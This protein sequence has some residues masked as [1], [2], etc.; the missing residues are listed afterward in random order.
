MHYQHRYHAGNFADVF[1]H[2][3]LVGLL[4]ALNRKESP[5]CYLETHAGTGLYDLTS[6]TADRTGEFRDG[7]E[8]LWGLKGASEP[9]TRY[10][11]G[12]RADNANGQLRN[13]PGSPRVAQSFMRE[14]DRLVL[15][16]KVPAM[17]DQLKLNLR[18]A[19]IH[20][21][22]GY[23]AISLL[24]PKEKRALILID[25][26]FE[27][28]DEFEACNEF[29]RA[30]LARFSQGI[31]AVW[32]PLKNAHVA[33]RFKRRAATLKRAVLTMEFDTGAKGEETRFASIARSGSERPRMDA[34]AGGS[35]DDAASAWMPEPPR[36][37]AMTACGLL[38]VN[39]PYRFAEEMEPTMRTLAELLAQGPRAAYQW[40]MLA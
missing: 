29:L 3:A 23:E 11:D 2:V 20:R 26:P 16:E 13:Y 37:H 12:V 32:Y 8:R 24:P 5:W 15:C 39:P 40:E 31:Y 17:A 9:L 30:A 18:V 28:P 10:L 25:P 1:K 4:A 19:E 27:R 7:I 14:T 38:I 34:R 36:K 6:V 33:D 21:R 35:L 22:D